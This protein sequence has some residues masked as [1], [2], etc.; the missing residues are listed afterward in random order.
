MTKW[1]FL[2]DTILAVPAVWNTPIGLSSLLNILKYFY[3]QQFR[4]G[5]VIFSQVS[6]K[7]SVHRGHAWQMGGGM[8][9]RGHA[10]QGMCMAGGM[11]GRRAC[12]AGGRG[13]HGG[14]VHGRGTCVQ[15]AMGCVWQGACMA[16]GMYGGVHGRRHVGGMHGWGCGRKNSN[17]SRQYASYWNV[18]S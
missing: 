18:I 14:G 8:H 3:C 5:K 7:N 17:C 13:V 10:W 6:V 2:L 1:D 15:C 9:G 12:M 4:C 11:Y 16:G